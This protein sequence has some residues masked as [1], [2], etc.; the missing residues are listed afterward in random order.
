M[1]RILSFLV[2]LFAS[3]IFAQVKDSSI[4]IIPSSYSLTME[5]PRLVRVGQTIKFEADSIYIVNKTRFS[6]YEEL[7]HKLLTLNFD[8]EPAIEFYKETLSKNTLLAQQL[9]DN[10]VNTNMLNT[11][12]V[13]DAQQ[14][15]NRN[16]TALK[17][18]LENMNSAKENL[19]LAKNELSKIKRSNFLENVLYTLAG[20]GV[21]VIV[22][23]SIN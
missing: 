23:V 10:S 3:Q 22:G 14:L 8:C 12:I 16:N 6:F 18:S 11:K 2:L 4:V 19:N 1:N 13:N 7:R 21:G 9:L 20:I 15:L 17:L 5:T